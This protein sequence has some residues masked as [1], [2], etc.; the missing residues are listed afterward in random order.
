[1]KHAAIAAMFTIGFGA[2][3]WTTAHA[4][5]ATPLPAE[6]VSGIGG[7]FFKARDPKSL[8]ASHRQALGVDV[9]AGAPYA[10]FRWRERED[11]SGVGATP[12]SL[13]P[14]RHQ[15]LRAEQRL[16]HDDDS[17]CLP[18]QALSS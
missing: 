2:G 12:W 16:V 4:G 7:V 17:N 1:M 13:F 14:K 15:V 11:A 8:A 10:A 6:R 5:Q 9:A 18:S 3:M